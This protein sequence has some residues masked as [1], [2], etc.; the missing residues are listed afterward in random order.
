[1]VKD[2]GAP[3]CATC[4]EP[5]HFD[6]DRDGRTIQSCGCG[7]REYLRTRRSDTGAVPVPAAR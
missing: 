5:L 1:M 7:H 3:R 2:A 6:S 4:A